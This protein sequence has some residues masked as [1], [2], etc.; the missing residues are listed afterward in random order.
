MTIENI[1]LIAAWITSFGLLGVIVLCHAQAEAAQAK[2]ANEW[3]LS[4]R[5]VQRQRAWVP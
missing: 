2:L 4:R 5:E 1:I 3:V